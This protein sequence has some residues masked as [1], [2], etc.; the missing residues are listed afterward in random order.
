M[1]YWVIIGWCFGAI[2]AAYAK[3]SIL[4]GVVLGTFLGP[5]ALVIV[6]FAFNL[7]KCPNCYEKIKKEAKTCKYCHKDV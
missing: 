4:A 5:F 7:K 1:L 6:L 2:S 3:Q